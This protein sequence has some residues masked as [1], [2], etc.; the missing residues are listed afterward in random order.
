[1]PASDVAAPSPLD[2]E[3]FGIAVARA[4]G[5]TAASVPLLVSFVEENGIEMVIARC[6]GADQEAARALAGAGMVLLEGQITYRGPLEPLSQQGGI[7]EGVPDD[8]E[9]VAELARAGFLALAGHYHAD[10][11]LSSHPCE[12][13]YVDW[14]LRGLSGD[15]ADVF[16]VAE[17][18]G[19]VAA[20]G[21]FSQSGAEVTFLLSTVAEPARGLGLYTAMLHRGMEWGAERGGEEMIGITGFGNIP[22]QRN[23]IRAGLRPVESTWTFHGWRDQ[24]AGGKG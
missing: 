14:A 11:R 13:I 7:R 8:A 23:L 21:M 22:A 24:I 1:M 15:A 18:E 6:D 19:R 5:V 17:V 3:R 9:V 12:E 16:Y 20:F 2:S 10:P 4:D